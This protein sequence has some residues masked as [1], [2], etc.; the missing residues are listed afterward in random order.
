SAP[1]PRA[2]CRSWLS[3]R[4]SQRAFSLPRLSFPERRLGRGVPGPLPGQS[5][6]GLWRND[7]EQQIGL[8][9]L[10]KVQGGGAAEDIRRPVARVV[11]QEGAAASQLILEVREPPAAC[12]GVFV[13]LAAD[14]EADAVTGRQHHAGGPDLDVQLHHLAGFEGLV[15]VV[16]VIWPPGRRQLLAELAVRGAEPALADGGV[17]VDGALEH[18]LLEIGSERTQ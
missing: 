4:R 7:G 2:A 8:A 11:V 15:P 12:A 13:V 9:A 10:A 1:A 14:R 6:A 17:R 18:H 3:D 16:G 5:C